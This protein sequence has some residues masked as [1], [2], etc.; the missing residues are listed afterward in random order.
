MA[1]D[2][3]SVFTTGNAPSKDWFLQFLVNLANKNRFELDITLTVGGFLI[4][5]T[6]AGVKQYFDDLGAYFASPFESKDNSE[7]VRTAFKKIGD[8][9]SCVSLSEQTE[10]PSYIHLKNARFFDAQG[11]SVSGSA[12]TWWRGRIS[13]VQGFA[14]G[15]LFKQSS[16]E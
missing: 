3:K 11:K 5:G 8:Q 12:G 6:L 7:E 16:L 15:V 4:S 13:E 9:C 1:K 14:P 10:T 2:E